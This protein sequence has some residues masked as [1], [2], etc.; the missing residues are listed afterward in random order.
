M[1]ESN[2]MGPL[3][4][5]R[6][7]DIAGRI[8]DE[9]GKALIGQR[10]MLEQ[11]VVALFAGGH[12]LLEGVPGLGKTLTVLALSRAFGGK[13]SRV[14]FTPDLMPSDLTGHVVYDMKSGEFHVRRGPA[15]ANLLLADEINRAPAKTQAALLEVMQEK[16]I[17]I[18]GTSH[19][20]DPPFM[21]LATQNPIELEGTYPLPEAQLDRFLLKITIEYP[22]DDEEVRLVEAVT[23][24]HI[25]DDLAVDRVD[26]I[27]DAATIVAIQ[28]AVASLVVDRQIVNYA[29]RI[30]RAT[31]SWPG[32]AIG[33]GPR[34]AIALIRASRSAALL[35]GRRFVLPDDVK[36][37]AVPALRHRIALTPDLEIEGRKSDEILGLVLDDIEAPKSAA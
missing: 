26:K 36:R 20:L 14:Q 13:F 35:A 29:V 32:I 12:V 23:Q 19:P 33:A 11:V 27:V 34:G 1:T 25:G 22:T 9:I 24:G 5:E 28:R 8:T 30:V 10:E 18:E 2:T 37:M 17:S 6:A 21:V 7:A 31:R 15:F 16:Q 4:P 3:G